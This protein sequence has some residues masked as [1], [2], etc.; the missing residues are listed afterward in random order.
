MASPLPLVVT[1]VSWPEVGLAFAVAAG[2]GGGAGEELDR[3]RGARR[4]VQ[5]AGDRG[6]VGRS[7]DRIVLQVVGAACRVAGVVSG[8]AVGPRSIPNRRWRRSSCP[9]C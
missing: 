2:V 5:R 9:E 4:A 7:E 1:L 6:A 3:E 8:H